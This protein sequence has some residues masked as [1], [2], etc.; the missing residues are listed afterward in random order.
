MADEKTKKSPQA[1]R[2]EIEQTRSH[3][4]GK[5]DTLQARLNPDRLKAEAK[6]KIRENTVGRV[7]ALAD[8]ASE[9]VKGTGAN[10]FDTIKQNP[11]PAALAAIGLGWLFMEGRHSDRQRFDR[12]YATGRS[13][14][15]E[16][17]GYDDPDMYNE[18]YRYYDRGRGYTREPMD[19]VRD[20]AD[21]ARQG[22]R[23]AASSVGDT[24]SDVASNVSDKASQVASNV[25][26]TASQ[27]RDQARERAAE[28]SDMAQERAY[29][30]KTRFQEIMDENPLLIGAAALAVGAAIGM[31]LPTTPQEDRLLGDTRD[32][33][34]DKVQEK[35][36]DTMDKVQTVAERAT[37]AAKETAK[38]EARNQG[39]NP[40]I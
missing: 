14:Y 9:T 38:N 21:Q 19:R 16:R 17:Y 40:N 2:R 35:A 12:R 32:R 33:V 26:D 7:E 5:I 31:S 3:M 28:F 23:Q 27:V 36:S 4:E 30:A 15:G 1:I 37:D 22:V 10:V 39:L 13:Y 25:S 6:Y 11:L 8:N 18:E 20:T 24:A 29:Q 34:M